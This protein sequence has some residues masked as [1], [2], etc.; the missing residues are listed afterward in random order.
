MAQKM[1]IE[2]LATMTQREFREIDKKMDQMVTKDMF[3]EGMDIVLNEI[4][5]VR[6]DVK[7][8]HIDIVGLEERLEV[9]EETNRPSKTRVRV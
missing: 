9:L 8:I 1:T 4:R 5:G 2:K 7:N 3:K 6:S